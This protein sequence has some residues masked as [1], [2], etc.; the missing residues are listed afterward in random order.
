MRGVGKQAVVLF[1]ILLLCLGLAPL[2]G[3]AGPGGSNGELHA[4]PT[5]NPVI[6]FP[7][8]PSEGG[9]SIVAATARPSGLRVLGGAAT[10][11]A[12][13][14]LVFNQDLSAA[15]VAVADFIAYGFT[16]TGL[17][18]S[19]NTVT[20]SG[21]AG[22]TAGDRIRV[23][24]IGDIA[25]ADLAISSDVSFIT[26]T[27]GPVITRVDLAAGGQD[28]TT[29]TDA[30]IVTFDADVDFGSGDSEDSAFGG[31]P[32]FNGAL[33]EYVGGPFA[34]ENF[35]VVTYDAASTSH[36][37]LINPGVTHL[38]LA[39]SRVR[40]EDNTTENS[41]EQRFP[42][43][44]VGPALV[45][46][47]W[48]G[49]NL[50]C[51]MSDAVDLSSGSTS[52]TGLFNPGGTWAPT[53]GDVA[54]SAAGEV[55][56]VLKVTTIDVAPA[57]G[58]T[59][60]NE[61]CGGPT[62]GC[63]ALVD[64]QGI[65]ALD[66]VSVAVNAGV[67][68]IRASYDDQQTSSRL[69][70][71]MYI[72]LNEPV[73][74]A[75]VDDDLSDFNPIGFVL[76]GLS[77]SDKR[78]DNGLTRIT[79]TGFTSTNYPEPGAR[80]QAVITDGT[81]IDGDN[82]GGN[83]DANAKVL[84]WDESRPY[85]LV[86][87]EDA[88]GTYDRW[89]AVD[90][91]DSVF[92]AWTESN[93][94]E[95]DYYYLFM[96]KLPPSQI[97]ATWM[98]TYLSSA[99]PLGDGDP[100][101]TNVS[102]G[103]STPIV[104]RH[105]IA[106]VP[107]VTAT[108]DGVTLVEGDQIYILVAAA[109]ASCNL[110]ARG[111][112][113]NVPTA[114]H[115][116]GAF[117]V[118]PLC[119]PRDFITDASVPAEADSA[120]WDHDVI[121]IVGDSLATGVTHYIYGDLGAIPCD[122]DSVVI[123]DGD[124]PNTDNRLGVGPV[125][126]DGSFSFIELLE[127]DVDVNCV[128]VF[129]KTETDLSTGT[130]IFFQRVYPAIL[131]DNDTTPYADFIFDAWNPYRTYNRNDYI[132]IRMLL[133]RNFV[134]C[135]AASPTAGA[136]SALFHA[137]AD[138]TQIDLTAGNVTGF[139][140]PADSI[141]FTSLGADN[142][143]NDGDWERSRDLDASGTIEVG[144]LFDDVGLDGVAGTND[145]GEGDGLATYG[146]PYVD[147]NGDGGY[148][149]GETFLDVVNDTDKGDHIYD[150]GEIDLDSNDG[151]EFGW[152]EVRQ[153]SSTVRGTVRQGYQL[154]NPDV[155]AMLDPFTPIVIHVEDNGIDGNVR[156]QYPA[157]RNLPFTDVVS[158]Y[159]RTMFHL[160][161]FNGG[162]PERRFAAVLDLREPTVGEITLLANES[163]AGTDAGANLIVP[164]NPVYN[165]GRFVDL[166]SS[167][168]S[169]RDVLYNRMRVRIGS[170]T[171]GPSGSWQDLALDPS[172][173]TGATGSDAN[174]DAYPGA[175]AY[176]E[177]ADSTASKSN[178]FDED[179][180]GDIDEVGEG[181]DFSDREVAAAAQDSVSDFA[182]SNSNGLHAQNDYTD[183][184]ND[185]FFVYDSY[186]NGGLSAAA[187]TNTGRIHWY[188]VDESTTNQF[189]DD[190]DGSTDESDEAAES[191]AYGNGSKDDNEDGIADGEAVE[192]PNGGFV[193]LPGMGGVFSTLA[194]N[195]DS[196]GLG[197]WQQPTP[198]P[199]VDS[200]VIRVDAAH[201][202]GRRP[203]N[204]NDTKNLPFYAN[205]TS[206]TEPVHGAFE[207]LTYSTRTFGVNGYD[208]GGASDSTSGENRRF[209]WYDTHDSENIDWELLNAIYG[210]TADGATVHQLRL[211]AY[212]KAGNVR[213][214][215]SEPI[216]F[217]LD[218][219]PPLATI[220]GCDDS[221][222]P[223]ADFA[224]V[225]SDDGVQIYDAG[226][227]PENYT[228][229]ADADEDAVEVTFEASFDPD[230][231]T[232]DFTATDITA[233]YTAEWPGSG[234]YTIN[235]YPAANADTVYFR[236]I[237]TDEFGNT[238]PEEDFC[239]LDV[240]VIDGTEPSATIVQIG[241]DTDME[242]GAC[243]APDSSIAIFAD[244]EDGDLNLDGDPLTWCAGLDT[245][246][247]DRLIDDDDD[248]DT[249]EDDAD[250][251]GIFTASV[252]DDG[253]DNIPGT[254]DDE[255]N[256]S[257]TGANNL[258]ETDD[259]ITN[260][261]VKVVFEFNPVAD[262]PDEG[263]LPIET[264]HGDPY[265]GDAP[266]VI[267]WTE[268]VHAT[269][270]TL[271]LETGNYDIR[272]Y[273]CD[274]EGNCDSTSAF[275][276]TVCIR[277][278]PLRAYIQP[279]V[280]TDQLAFDLYAVHYIHDYEI[281]KVRFEYYADTNGD[282]CANDGNN[283]VAID[284]DDVNSGRGDAVL[285]RPSEEEDGDALEDLAY[286]E[287]LSD[288][289]YRFW[290]PEN[291]GYSSRDPVVHDDNEDGIFQLSDDEV[292]GEDN[293]IP[294]G[295]TLTSFAADEYYANADGEDLDQDS[296]IFK[297]NELTGTNGALD[298]WTVSWDATGLAEGN[299][300]TRSIAIDATNQE[301]VITYTCYNPSEQ[302]PEEIELVVLDSVLPNSNIDNITLPDGTVVDVSTGV[303]TPYVNGSTPWIKICMTADDDVARLLLEYSLNG[304]TDWNEIDVNNDDDFYSNLDGNAGFQLED[305]DEVI[306][307]EIFNDLNGNYEYD[308]P[309][310]D[311]VRSDGGDGSVDTPL[312][313]PLIPLSGEDENAGDGFEGV[314]NDG[315]GVVDEDPTSGTP[316]SQAGS[317][318]DYSAPF[319]FYLDIT[320]LPLWADVN[321]L[322]RSTAYDQVCD[323]YRADESPD[324]LSVI[325]GENQ[326]P[327]ADIVRAE[328]LD[329]VQLDVSPAIH[330][331]DGCVTLGADVDTMRVFVTAED[332]TSVASVDLYYRLD[333]ACYPDLTLEELQWTSMTTDGYTA[334]D[335][336]YPYDFN[337]ATDDIPDGAY[338][339]FPKA[340]DPTG[341]ATP[342]PENPWCFKKFANA[343]VDFAYVSTPAP[344]PAASDHAAVGDE[345]TIH[346]S[347]TDP[348]EAPTTAVQ[349]YYAARI[350][351]ESI[352]PTTV[353][354]LSPYLSASLDR[355]ISG[356]DGNAVVV[357]VNG[358]VATYYA[359]LGDAS[360]P[361]A[362]D[363]TVD[364]ANNSIE[365]GARPAGTDVIA[366][367][368]NITGY[369]QINTGDTWSPYTVAW[370]A[371]D[372]GVPDPEDDDVDAYDLIAI[373]RYDVNGDG[374]YTG[375]DGCDY[376]EPLASEGNY[377]ILDDQERPLVI[378]YG[379]DWSSDQPDDQGD[380]DCYDL[381]WPGN[382][383]F[384]SGDNLGDYDF[385]A[386]LSGVE[387]D[388]FVLTE[389]VG[390]SS[391]DSVSL[392]IT[393]E[394][395]TGNATPQTQTFAMTLYDESASYIDIPVTMYEDDYP[396]FT[397]ESLENVILQISDSDG[398]VWNRTYE[399]TDMGDYWQAT[400]RFDVG[401]EWTYQ[402][403]VDLIGDEQ[404]A[405]DDARND[406]DGTPG[407]HIRIPGT[408][409]WYQHL[410]N[411]VDLVNNAVHTV[412]VTAWDSAGNSGNNLNSGMPGDPSDHQGEIVFVHDRTKPV[413]EAII[414]TDD[415]ERPLSCDRVSPI[416]TYR[417]WPEISDQPYTDLNVLAVAAARVEYTPNRG[418]VWLEIATDT[419]PGSGDH[420]GVSWSPV[421]GET[422][423]YDNDG[424]GLWDEEDERIYQVTI[425]VIAIDDG[426]NSGYS[427]R[428]T[429]A[430]TYTITVDNAQPT[431]SLSAPRN[432]DVFDY[433]DTI[434][435]TGTAEGDYLPALGDNDI[436]EARF[437]VRMGGEQGNLFYVDDEYNG[438]GHDGYYD[439]GIDEI[440]VDADNDGA[441][442]CESDDNMFPG[443]D[444]VIDDDCDGGSDEGRGTD[445]AETLG[446]PP[447]N[448]WFDL[449]PT[450]IDNSDLPALA[451]PNLGDAYQ[452][453]W[454]PMGSEFV[455]W[456]WE[457]DEWQI[458]EYVRG[459]LLTKDCA[460]NWD[461]DSD[462]FG[463]PTT[464]FILD[465][466][467]T[468]AAYIT[469]IDDRVIDPVETLAIQAKDP[470]TVEG[471]INSPV[472]FQIEMVKVFLV[473]QPNDILISIDTDDAPWFGGFAVLW[474]A[475]DL[476]E[477]TYQL[478]AITV[479]EDGNESDPAT[480]ARVTVR[481][482]RTAPSVVYAAMGDAFSGFTTSVAY[483]DDGQAEHSSQVIHPDEFTHDVIFQAATPDADVEAMEL[484]WRFFVDPD[485][486]WRPLSDLLDG[487]YTAFDYE[488]NLNFESGGVTYHV[489]RVH[490]E[491]F[492]DNLESE[493]PMQFRAL[494]T[495]EAG[496]SNALQT[497]VMDLTTDG[498]DPTLFDWNDD[499]VTN[500]VEVGS[501]TNFELT[502]QD[503]EYTDV[504]QVQLE[505]RDVTG[506][507][508]WTIWG[509]DTAPTSVQLDTEFAMWVSRFAWVAPTFVVHDTQYEFRI[510]V[511]DSAWNMA[512]IN[513]PNGE[514]WTLTVED[515]AAP[516]RTKIVDV[517]G[518]VLYNA[519]DCEGAADPTDYTVNHEVFVDRNSDGYYDPGTDFVISE[520]DSPG[521]ECEFGE[522]DDA[523]TALG[524]VCNTYP[525]Q[526]EEGYLN[527]ANERNEVRVARTVTIVGR[528][529]ADDDGIDSGIAYVTFWARQFDDGGNVVATYELGKDEYSP[530]FP[531]YYWHVT[532]ATD[533]LDVQ[534]NRKYADGRYKL[535]ATGTDSEGNVEQLDGAE[536]INAWIVVDN[537][538][539][540]AQMDADAHTPTIEQTVTV[541][542][543]SA[544]TLFTRTLLPGSNTENTYED[545]TITWYFKRSRDLNMED[546]WGLV[547][548]ASGIDDE[549]DNPDDN[550]PYSMD[551]YLGELTEPT[552]TSNDVPLQVG[553]SYDF[554]A[555][556]SDQNCNETS[557]ITGFDDNAVPGVG[558]RHIT[559]NIIDT[560]APCL[561]IV[562]IEVERDS[563]DPEYNMPTKVH[564]R[565]IES[566][567]ARLLTGDKDIDHVEFVYRKKGATTWNLIDADLDWSEDK[568]DWSI[569]EW[570]L[571]ALDH[572]SWY[573]IAAIGVDDVGNVCT[574]PDIVE[575][576]VDF[577]APPMTLVHPTPTTSKWCDYEWTSQGRIMDLIVQVDRGVDNQHD[578]VDE[579]I[580]EFKP[581]SENEDEF[582]E[583]ATADLDNYDDVT[584]RYSTTIDL[585]DLEDD[586]YGSDLY[587]LRVR[588]RDWAD[589]QDTLWVWRNTVD[590][591]EANAVQVSNIW[592]DGKDTTQDPDDQG[593]YTDVTAGT[594]VVIFGTASDDENNLPNP[595]EPSDG[596]NYETG[597]AVMQFQV[598]TDL[599]L[600]GDGDLDDG[601]V[602]RDLGTIYIDPANHGDPSAVSDSTLWNTTGLVEG[603]YFV[604]VGVQDE[605]QNPQS[606]YTWSSEV[607]VRITDSE[608]PIARIACWDADIQL[609]GDDPPSNIRLYALAESDPNI[610]DVQFQY[611]VRSAGETTP[612]GEWVNIG[613]PAVEL[614]QDDNNTETVWYTDIRPNDFDE[615]VTSLWLRAL[616]KDSDGNRYGDN[617]DDVVP[618]IAVNIT[619]LA[620]GMVTF[621]SIPAA[622]QQ[623]GSEVVQDVRI[624][625]VSPNYANNGTFNVTVKMASADETPRVLV[626]EEQTEPESFLNDDDL[627][628]ISAY[629]EDDGRMV[630][631]IDDPTLWT[632]YFFFDDDGRGCASYHVC[633]TG[634]DG[635]NGTSKWVDMK[636]VEAREFAVDEERGTNGTV[637]VD[638]YGEL[639]I[640]TS[641]LPGAWANDGCLL[642][643]PTWAPRISHDQGM[644]LQYVENTSYHLEIWIDDSNEGDGSFRHGYEPAVTI[645][646]DDADAAAALSGT[647]YGEG[648]LTVRRWD[649]TYENLDGTVGAWIGT[650][651]A[652]IHVDAA[653]NTV[654]FT[655]DNLIT[656][657]YDGKGAL[658][659][660]Y[661]DSDGNLFALFAPK[662]DGPVT[663]AGWWPQSPYVSDVWTNQVPDI[664]VYL[665]DI[666]GQMV[667]PQSVEL[668]I[669]GE[670]W[671]TWFDTD[672]ED[673]DCWDGTDNEE[674]C[675]YRASFTRGD[676]FAYTQYANGD[677]T[678]MY[679]HYQH[680]D[681]RHDR[682]ANGEHRLTVRWKPEDGTDEWIEGSQ[683][684]YVDAISPYVEFDGGWVSNPRL[685]NLA[686]YMNPANDSL[687]VKMYDGG[688]GILFRHE[689]WDN[690]GWSNDFGVKYD[691]WLVDGE[692]DQADIDEIEERVL[693]HQ[694]TA[695]D[696]LP[697]ISPSLNDYNPA[698]DTLRVPVPILGGGAIKDR[699]I[700]EI[701]WYSDKDIERNS[702]GIGVGC[703]IDTMV[704]D[705]QVFHVYGLDCA[706][707][708][709]SQEMHIYNYGVSDWAGNNGSRYVEQRFIVDMTAPACVF[710]TASTVDPDG[711]IHIE[712]EFSEDGAGVDPAS[713]RVRVTDPN[714]E[715]VTVEDLEIDE[716]G[717]HGHIAAPLIR[718]EYTITVEVRDL[719]G[720]K[721]VSTKT[722]RVE[723]AVLAM[724]EPV[725]YPNPFDPSAGSVK[726]AFGLSRSSHVTV[727][728]Y[729]FGGNYVTTLA[730][731]KA[732]DAGDGRFVLWGGE[733][734]DGTDL[735]NGTYFAHVSA[736]DGTKTEEANLKVVLWRE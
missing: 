449:D 344:P 276:T 334:I 458:D 266:Q 532:W 66:A 571:E 482:D 270:N 290:D 668:L 63:D 693:L 725:V 422:D 169:D 13:V 679:L 514:P 672:F 71:F 122:A 164:G 646:Y 392:A 560:I 534:G 375:N 356:S 523:G 389:D 497:T 728:L 77:I 295:A 39:Q 411:T 153:S 220:P 633:V 372:G 412:V 585:D 140:T 613:V 358:V 691:I 93:G 528:T 214:L 457:D 561:E 81:I 716:N 654:T 511:W 440:W 304:G 366:V 488:P 337:V 537:E 82:S 369:S 100:Q 368:Y 117:L 541:Q 698:T 723:A 204:G 645:Q 536:W 197:L 526:F 670:F 113:S 254:N 574:N 416:E 504:V 86:I 21:V 22:A 667:N 639:G 370:S 296:W 678:V 656:H 190:N 406:C 492:A 531:L 415:L 682:L 294:E 30:I 161:A 126:A 600:P 345:Y 40:W 362:T 622:S 124:D 111:D 217:T 396:Q 222:D 269:W 229:T 688:S 562:R 390:G 191:V 713:I 551:F 591:D 170:S 314:D 701:T 413:V 306:N 441:F 694:G 159:N 472:T 653:A 247:G 92:V 711:E 193:T 400:A 201:V 632:G 237:A 546:S 609:H 7:A 292:I 302:N 666:S 31:T 244:I 142:V 395:L 566:I 259:Y 664:T 46:A 382:P 421:D 158:D 313:W 399:M 15:S 90:G 525:R 85:G 17:S 685:I 88:N 255:W 583:Y 321:V 230:F 409:F 385:V 640:S 466:N 565:A 712:I 683:T 268:P 663:F 438:V 274:I 8:F 384:N 109:D 426:Y 548:D 57:A 590:V 210:L 524:D 212:D 486:L 580:F 264:V 318:E 501:T 637:S 460:G 218:L 489:W 354:P 473:S 51:V 335:Y 352:D 543:N 709:Q 260:D 710:H 232:I 67:G 469:E 281:D 175:Q 373:A 430:V 110:S 141:L 581:S 303:P 157:A 558:V 634:L 108:T 361:S 512:T 582:E 130:Q 324:V 277:N 404:E 625:V 448:V 241:N 219:D 25:N 659:G 135:G 239:V 56:T 545:D 245:K 29:F 544:F 152:Y 136:R 60:A 508:E 186:A 620:S 106:I 527:D 376:D 298:R 339:F 729:D 641:I 325:I 427:D 47:Y 494:A 453:T 700:I 262:S 19:A 662:S 133:D 530:F 280:C 101:A 233:P 714:G 215:W 180:D 12:D 37:H 687:M 10:T 617:P 176:D 351:D 45:G 326:A 394:V 605:C 572:N 407:S 342:A 94:T 477:G 381:N 447:I 72:W 519:A 388:V 470:V 692:D 402:F 475:T 420:W 589:N 234:M 349:F 378:L 655:V 41:T 602:W 131:G 506:G 353:Q 535:A 434:T 391:V 730:T 174:A 312:G 510:N 509:A 178:G 1:S 618:V 616:A 594:R 112:L 44:N 540:A 496:N 146:D 80:L 38:V 99:I 273:A 652:H 104:L 284:L 635:T 240:V 408:P 467:T 513:H 419:N 454:N 490:S 119:P 660:G 202:F 196:F 643:A 340:W 348:S 347:L 300:L 251:D 223:P 695:D 363:Y 70:D 78:V 36:P 436:E 518:V 332:M 27:A 642:V 520:G 83:I 563:G 607:N 320:T 630:R 487:G 584:N 619:R 275:I 498:T 227:H 182:S 661:S 603:Q 151:D 568:I 179:E 84:I 610:V 484:Q 549:D 689:G 311:F 380:D 647:E 272:A 423:G 319:C 726:I 367:S 187:G 429:P 177:D 731:N 735:A 696:L 357:T 432:G 387:S 263:W 485:G 48:D 658:Q 437:Q 327:E 456:G 550:R 542:R 172:A 703:S 23:A 631:S 722:V 123:Y 697:W 166:T 125:N 236:A 359:D 271:D 522:G 165:L 129:S 686:G 328:D 213:E 116:F 35:F 253:A 127:T 719:L 288:T 675:G 573:E 33:L 648:N 355:G 718:G 206:Y 16:F 706:Y 717:V 192:M 156:T 50:W 538:A 516:D 435:F 242:D 507:G 555:A 65:V 120:D 322:F 708:S 450:P 289:F 587:D 167:T 128:W 147:E 49:T 336:T 425:R 287:D 417:I 34:D 154:V 225:S 479:D 651:I 181:I 383:L 476:A 720:N 118:G 608:P 28:S 137:W 452:I 491:D 649:S 364:Y 249:D 54:L 286:R 331:D 97:T 533:E 87:N 704:V 465:D 414:L 246:T 24:D 599:P 200:D 517:E 297:E 163:A 350:M 330:D 257:N 529:Q 462:G 627:T 732:M 188:N 317:P 596:Y 315:D 209:N 577:E 468:P 734:A 397:P 2:A 59:L 463:P 690:D 226:K 386:K 669:D 293:E 121:H 451:E 621:E 221:G 557:H 564:A 638:A 211:N 9:P 43:T 105:G 624:E 64:Y 554:M 699:D 235:N 623:G 115:L 183:N 461:D 279:E 575:V 69:D 224:D 521:I 195:W 674:I 252:D 346:G 305:A 614:S 194:I 207:D 42:F 481:I 61:N 644:Y 228:L 724:T 308:G 76:T 611:N 442:D 199:G 3:A 588:I 89:N 615:T 343:G 677:Q 576:Y 278:E 483:T 665:K 309:E 73:D 431:A 162:D 58:A 495:D 265:S 185:A 216:S 673:E 341:N 552:D 650:G 443:Q 52:F 155:D 256:G 500:Q 567:E 424:D 139:G 405:I 6:N 428:Q 168:L 480:A 601:E 636:H 433:R 53:T 593:Q 592:W 570:D 310:V 299:Y 377:L 134:D 150:P 626:I 145:Q 478:Y 705:G 307:D 721:C 684:F 208:L 569:S 102:P 338:Q 329:G 702:D 393:A 138:F 198:G 579:V 143:D 680:S 238:T 539:P 578:D 681:H 68:I 248:G 301:D 474:D 606:D 595:S 144:E 459:R 75:E 446:A 445:G 365:F 628:N 505:Y 515:N 715:V 267:D 360:S 285:Y 149:P 55:T 499:S 671:A 62:P 410:D 333:P 586:W 401:T 250:G 258:D 444:G 374:E 676:A 556:V 379:L 493:G 18:V 291:D 98:R 189:D 26:L 727:K 283:W 14:F 612:V 657:F 148:D 503:L 184:D 95:G 403:V 11:E 629:A 464:I 598:A 91:V 736:T 4:Y 231:D 20:L 316:P 114:N 733:A 547:P 418:G 107:T 203:V 261:I 132:N 371:D 282:Q 398:D 96:T 553:E 707:D 160:K 173:A 455:R 471:I 597:I 103:T 171:S 79:V 243:V 74:L 439:N 502:T 604:R 5:I 323:I 559:M 205:E 32:E